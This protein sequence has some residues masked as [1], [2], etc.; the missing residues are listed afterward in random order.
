MFYVIVDQNGRYKCWKGGFYYSPFI[1]SPDLIKILDSVDMLFL[2][3]SGDRYLT[4]N[5]DGSPY[6]HGEDN[7]G[8]N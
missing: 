4:F 2:S 1:D 3:K 5:D 7:L 8:V 6:C